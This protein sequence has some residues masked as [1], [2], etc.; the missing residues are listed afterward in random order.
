MIEK[1][2][3]LITLGL[4]YYIFNLKEKL[5]LGS[6]P[7]SVINNN[8]VLFQKQKTGVLHKNIL[9]IKFQ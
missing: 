4:L 2:P 1:L 7:F 8:D 9:S 5:A 6:L 3:S